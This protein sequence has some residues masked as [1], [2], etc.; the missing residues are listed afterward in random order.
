[1]AAPK[2]HLWSD[3]SPSVRSAF[4]WAAASTVESGGIPSRQPAVVAGA[5]LIGVIRS[6]DGRSEPEALLE[7]FGRT[8]DDLFEV[9]EKVIDGEKTPEAQFEVDPRVTSPRPLDDFPRLSN[10]VEE[11]L[12][13]SSELAASAD[14]APDGQ[15]HLPTLFGGIPRRDRSAPLQGEAAPARRG[16]RVP[17]RTP[18]A[19]GRA[20]DVGR[21][22]ADPAVHRQLQ[23]GH[24]GRAAGAPGRRTSARADRRRHSENSAV[25]AV[26]S[27]GYERRSAR[28]S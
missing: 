6:H 18:R 16:P 28:E 12:R 22:T 14:P 17:A 7:H 27:R 20:A 4:E 10:S 26:F 21:A 5:L 2:Q 15:L 24:R 13:V 9:L 11:I 3:L 25:G 1:M 23:P 19:R 8:R